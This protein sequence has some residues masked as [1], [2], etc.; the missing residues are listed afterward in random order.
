MQVLRAAMASGLMRGSKRN[1]SDGSR[2]GSPE[3]AHRTRSVLMV[4]LP[5]TCRPNVL[6]AHYSSRRQ[7]RVMLLCLILLSECT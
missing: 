1:S 3:Q 7:R 6:L 5:D 4:R 2:R